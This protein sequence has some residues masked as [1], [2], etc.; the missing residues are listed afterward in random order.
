MK[1]AT[2]RKI[3]TKPVSA[4]P[5]SLSRVSSPPK[6]ALSSASSRAKTEFLAS[7]FFRLERDLRRL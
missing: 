6:N 7:P 2:I 5:T 3:A 4:L 1:G